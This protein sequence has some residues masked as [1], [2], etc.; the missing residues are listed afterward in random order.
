MEIMGAAGILKDRAR[1]LEVS[2]RLFGF[3]RR[4][5]YGGFLDLSDD[6]Q[7]KRHRWSMFLSSDVKNQI[8]IFQ[9]RL[10]G[11]IS[12]YGSELDSKIEPHFEELEHVITAFNVLDQT[13]R[14]SL[15]TDEIT[16]DIH[17]SL[18]APAWSRLWRRT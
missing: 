9:Q 16:R 3:I 15:G 8:D 4:D 14:K 13:V 12:F 5:S 2:Q 17:R 18:S 11:L 1:G 6:F 7:Q 10:D